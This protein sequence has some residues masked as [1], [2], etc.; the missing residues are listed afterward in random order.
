MTED[1]SEPATTRATT[2]PTD[3]RPATTTATSD[4][5]P[6]S[7][8]PTRCPL[9]TTQPTSRKPIPKVRRITTL[10]RRTFILTLQNFSFLEPNYRKSPTET[11]RVIRRTFPQRTDYD[12]RLRLRRRLLL[13]FWQKSDG[14]G[15]GSVGL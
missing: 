7:E 2:S 6:A 1:R 11:A 13:R 12:D 3:K 9:P 5:R 10:S 15:K 4:A 8:A 14:N